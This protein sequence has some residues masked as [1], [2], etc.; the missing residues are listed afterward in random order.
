MGTATQGGIEWGTAADG[1]RIYTEIADSGHVPYTLVPSGTSITWGS[2]NAL[3][4]AIGKILWQTADPIAGTVDPGAVSVANGVVYAGSEDK[5]GH[6][7]A[8]DAAT[9]KILWSFVGG[10]PCS[11]G[12]RLWIDSYIGALG[13]VKHP[14]KR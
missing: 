11:M 12:P 8:L 13:T 9:G 2:W 4:V 14:R 5:A 7:Y 3:D 6:F 10:A 1:Q